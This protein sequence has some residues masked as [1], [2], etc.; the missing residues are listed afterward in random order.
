MM[1]VAWFKHLFGLDI[2]KRVEQLESGHNKAAVEGA[3]NA[4]KQLVR[5][6]ER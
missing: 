4:F 3:V 2:R 5:D 1:L 6:A